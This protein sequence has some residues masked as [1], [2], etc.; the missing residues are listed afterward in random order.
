[1]CFCLYL[2]M[3]FNQAADERGRT[4]INAFLCY[5]C[6]SVAGGTGLAIP[7]FSFCLPAGKATKL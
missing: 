5:L 3:A 2:T 6:S 4:Q 1:M 7:C